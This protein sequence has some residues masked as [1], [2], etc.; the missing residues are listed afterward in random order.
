MREEEI[1]KIPRKEKWKVWGIFCIT[2][3]ILLIIYSML[4][5]NFLPRAVF[6]LAG[7]I[8]LLILGIKSIKE[9]KPVHIW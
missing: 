1:H 7:G 4:S 9:K 6:F 3:G 5:L 2:F 8:I